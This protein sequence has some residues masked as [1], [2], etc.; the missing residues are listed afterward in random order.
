MTWLIAGLGNPGPAYA[1]TRHNVGYLVTDVL[2]ERV[3]G[4]WKS[5]RASRAEV[6]EGRLAGERV[7]LGRSRSYMN[8]SGGPVKAMATF[9]DVEPEHL[10]VVH[11]ELDI[12]FGQLRLKLG[13][14]DNGHNGLKSIRG[15]LGTGD[16]HRVRVGIGRPPGQQTVHDYVL[17]PWSAAER[18]ELDLNVVEAADAVESL[19][20]R[21]L[22]ATQSAFNR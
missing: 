1:A 22:E 21:G 11:D 9:F 15:S 13:G 3:G 5:H 12:D 7:V 6:V 19:L 4:R 8:E 17:K 14:G 10:V 20:T 16:F 2:A 18:K